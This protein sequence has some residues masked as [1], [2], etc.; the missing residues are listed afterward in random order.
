MLF[1]CDDK[2]YI[3]SVSIKTYYL[4]IECFYNTY[5]IEYTDVLGKTLEKF[6]Y[7]KVGCFYTNVETMKKIYY[8]DRNIDNNI[9]N[10]IMKLNSFECGYG[11]EFND[12]VIIITDNTYESDTVYYN[13]K[14]NTYDNE[15]KELVEDN[16]YS[17]FDNIISIKDNI[18]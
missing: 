16:R 3:I 4:E 5:I 6:I 15:K 13:I 1:N 10:N 14:D 2:A 17:I 8:F 18:F 11:I 9:N 7:N 12:K